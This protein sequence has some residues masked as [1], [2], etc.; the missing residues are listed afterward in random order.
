M[1]KGTSG[2][3]GRVGR[4]TLQKMRSN[5][6]SLRSAGLLN[7]DSR[8]DDLT[9]E[10]KRNRRVGF[11]TSRRCHGQKFTSATPKFNAVDNE[12]P[13][14]GYAIFWKMITVENYENLKGRQQWTK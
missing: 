5:V 7:E 9:G 8:Y 12:C 13:D 2:Q 3:S 6:G 1:G 14:C 11:C 4:G 10:P